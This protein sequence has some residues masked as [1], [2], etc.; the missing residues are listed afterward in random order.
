MLLA[1]AFAN[2]G[3]MTALPPPPLSVL[4]GAALFLDFDGTLVEL[5]E[6]P[7]AIE[8]PSDFSDL[9][10]QLVRRLDGRVAIVSGRSL[11]DLERH[12]GNPGIAASG[13]HGLELR[14]AGG[15]LL[16]L[17][18]PV[19]LDEVREEIARFA[20]SVPGL[21]IEEKPASI[22]LHYRAAPEQEARVR[23]FMANLGKRRG[24]D[25]QLGKMVAELRPH[26]ADKG[27]ALRSLMAEPPFEGSRPVYVGD[28]LTDEHAFE[29]ASFLGGCGIL[30][31]PGRQTA[32]KYRLDGVEAVT[33]WLKEAA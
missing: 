29:A 17:H 31:G 30:V 15:E 28:D 26:G 23:S 24:L 9:I 10:Q 6:A 1:A 21:L 11:K 13:S 12:I 27:D 14:L 8:V 5:A 32:A 18:S 7:D 3:G 16:A 19:R 22:A 25:L 2:P 33:A 4:E 20:A